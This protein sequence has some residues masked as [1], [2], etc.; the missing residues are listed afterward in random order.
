M[1]IKEHKR[2]HANIKSQ[3]FQMPRYTVD[4]LKYEDVLNQRVFVLNAGH[5][6]QTSGICQVM[7]GP[8]MSCPA[9]WGLV[10]LLPF[11]EQWQ[12]RYNDYF[13]LRLPLTCSSSLSLSIYA[14]I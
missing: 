14:G 4:H 7:S 11:A 5:W 9:S 6:P 2:L 13:H 12:P 3:T 10:F 8:F 1:T